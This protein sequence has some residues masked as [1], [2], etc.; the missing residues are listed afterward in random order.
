MF[1]FRWTVICKS[2]HCSQVNHN[3]FFFAN[4]V[5]TSVLMEAKNWKLKAGNSSISMEKAKAKS[6][7][8]TFEARG[9]RLGAIATSCSFSTLI[10]RY[11]AWREEK[12]PPQHSYGIFWVLEWSIRVWFL[13]QIS[14]LHQSR[15]EICGIIGKTNHFVS[16][17]I[18]GKI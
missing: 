7:S 9:C 18:F 16:T 13:R 1:Q 11:K 8:S 15:A 17:K 6:S 10:L 5:P 3:R 12:W 4:R 14:E 2:I